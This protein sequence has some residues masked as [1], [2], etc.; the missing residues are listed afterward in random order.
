MVC[1]HFDWFPFIY[2]LSNLLI[3]T[4]RF[5]FLKCIYFITLLCK[6]SLTVSTCLD[7]RKVSTWDFNPLNIH[8]VLAIS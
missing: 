4:H 6:Q 3:I 2:I 5:K 1:W 7:D 8:Y